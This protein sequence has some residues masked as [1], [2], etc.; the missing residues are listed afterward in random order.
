MLKS[1]WI[2]VISVIMLL[3]AHGIT[4]FLVGYYTSGDGLKDSGTKIIAATEA[5]PLAALI[6]NISSIKYLYSMIIM[7]GIVF[8]LYYYFRKKYKDKDMDVVESFATMFL[9]IAFL[10]FM[11]DL[12]YL[13]G[14]LMR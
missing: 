4:Q 1:D 10:D 8:S 13:L 9:M 11:N 2:I 3:G 14:V 12:T 7:P 6:L 5:N